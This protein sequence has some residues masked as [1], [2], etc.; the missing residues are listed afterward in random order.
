VLQHLDAK[1]RP[2]NL[3]RQGSLSP[4]GSLNASAKRPRN[5]HACLRKNARPRPRD[6]DE[7]S[8]IAARSPFVSAALLEKLVFGSGF[9]IADIVPSGPMD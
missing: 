1:T 7:N 8:A 9:E 3:T 5:F 6:A 4:I 2:T